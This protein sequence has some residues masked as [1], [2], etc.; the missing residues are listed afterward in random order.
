MYVRGD[1][2]SSKGSGSEVYSM[3]RFFTVT[4]VRL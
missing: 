3:K 1:V 2:P 4:G